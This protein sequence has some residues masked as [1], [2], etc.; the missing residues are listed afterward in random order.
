M[1]DFTLKDGVKPYLES[2]REYRFES[3]LSIMLSSQIA[4]F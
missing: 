2:I 1:L 3:R 4:R